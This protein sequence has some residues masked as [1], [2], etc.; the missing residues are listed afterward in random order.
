M[1]DDATRDGVIYDPYWNS[2]IAC[3]QACDGHFS[4][5]L[6]TL[7]LSHK[8]KSSVFL[9]SFPTL[10]HSLGSVPEGLAFCL[11]EFNRMIKTH[12]MV[13][14]SVYCALIVQLGIYIYIY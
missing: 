13:P 8:F 9:P 5:S 2:N 7:S 1:I 12:V 4:S 14:E 3:A 10:I 11:E 6:R